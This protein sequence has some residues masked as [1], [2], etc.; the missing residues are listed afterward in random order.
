MSSSIIT[1]PLD[2]SMPIFTEMH[3]FKHSISSIEC[4]LFALIDCCAPYHTMPQSSIIS[5]NLATIAIESMLYGIFLVLAVS[6]LYLH[7]SRARSHQ[8]S[9][10]WVHWIL[11]VT[12][13]FAAFV[14]IHKE[15]D[16]VDY[17][18]N[19]SSATEIVK[20]AFF[21]VTLMISD[22]LFIYR[23][24]IVWSCNKYIIILPVCTF[25]GLCAQRTVVTVVESAALYSY[26]IF[27]QRLDCRAY[28][29]FYFLSY[30]LRSNIQYTAIDTLCTV[31]GITFMLVNVRVG[32]GW[33][34][35]AQ[36]PTSPSTRHSSS[37]SNMTSFRMRPVA[38][39]ITKVVDETYDTQSAQK[40]TVGE[41]ILPV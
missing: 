18:T 16:S 1:G 3:R 32:L 14:H 17:L 29:I 30:Q 6:A 10:Y 40:I 11:T 26:S 27:D 23:L 12:R 15:R 35:R 2:A 31:C 7:L 24:W 25:L 13:L 39:N 5:V 21:F 38:V 34:Q 19:L 36:S 22:V 41:S 4:Y 20:T 37:G 28:T 9:F 33:A 8:S